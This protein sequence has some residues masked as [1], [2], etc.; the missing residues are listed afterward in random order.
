[1]GKGGIGRGKIR[2]KEEEGINWEK[3]EEDRMTRRKE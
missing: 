1:L 3:E 2:W